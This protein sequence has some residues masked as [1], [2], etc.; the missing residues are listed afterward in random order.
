MEINFLPA[1]VQGQL[2]QIALSTS[3]TSAIDTGATDVTGPLKYIF[4][5]TVDMWI[6]FYPTN[7]AELTDPVATDVTGDTIGMF[8][9]AG[10]SFPWRCSA[11]ESRYFKAIS[12]SSG[13]LSYVR[14]R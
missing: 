11:R 10:V 2:Y 9:P 3:A 5:P 4:T 8:V 12:T 13:Y 14:V 6:K 7:G 1:P